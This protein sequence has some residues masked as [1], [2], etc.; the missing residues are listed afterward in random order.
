MLGDFG[1]RDDGVSVS[2]A[3]DEE[4]GLALTMCCMVLQLGNSV[5]D[6]VGSAVMASMMIPFLV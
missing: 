2:D 3:V 1:C 4:V 5:G 6:A